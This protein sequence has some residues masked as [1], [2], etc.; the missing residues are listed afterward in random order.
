MGNS[1]TGHIRSAPLRFVISRLTPPPETPGSLVVTQT[2]LAY[3]LSRPGA[4][5]E[6]PARATIEGASAGRASSTANI[7]TD[8]RDNSERQFRLRF[9]RN[10]GTIAQVSTQKLCLSPHNRGLC[11]LHKIVRSVIQEALFIGKSYCHY[12]NICNKS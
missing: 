9:C 7:A 12:G 6:A 11:A 3:R 5:F 2:G 1:G 4:S 8:T 10:V